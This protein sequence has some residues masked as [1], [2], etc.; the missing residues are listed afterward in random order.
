MP[1]TPDTEAGFDPFAPGV[2]NWRIGLDAGGDGP[3]LSIGT[4][5]NGKGPTVLVCG[6]THGDE[7]EGQMAVLELLRA[8]PSLTIDG[9]LIVVPFHHEAACRAGSRISP[10]DGRD[11]NRCYGL[12]DG[13]AG[14]ATGAI[15][16]F[17]ETAILP[18]IDVV[19]DLHSGG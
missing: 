1:T 18:V 4:A 16:G 11:L 15:A 10:A 12:G 7:F 14:G 5:G 2:R 9:R 3:R 19:I 6:G 8:L 13:A 17:V